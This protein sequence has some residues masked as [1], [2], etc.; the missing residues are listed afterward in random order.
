MLVLRKWELLLKLL[1]KKTKIL[2]FQDKVLL[3]WYL[4][5]NQDR[6]WN[7]WITIAVTL[8]YLSEILSL[9]TLNYWIYSKWNIYPFSGL[10]IKSS[11]IG[12]FKQWNNYLH[13]FELQYEKN[14][15][16]NVSDKWSFSGTLHSINLL[17]TTITRH[18][19]AKWIIYY[20]TVALFNLMP[21]FH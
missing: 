9:F 18:K 21:N 7:T 10:L 3:Y 6:N 12:H 4:F 17:K 5:K 20:Q 19:I 2:F 8:F 13:V 1:L 11:G 14:V 15:I 16:L